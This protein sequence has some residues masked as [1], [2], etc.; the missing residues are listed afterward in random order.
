MNTRRPS[1]SKPYEMRLPIAEGIIDSSREASLVNRVR[2]FP[3]ECRSKNCEGAL[4]TLPSIRWKR[5]SAGRN[6]PC[7]HKKARATS[8]AAERNSA[9]A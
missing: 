6:V 9:A 3:A 8:E 2:I 4:I 7:R 1:C 5:L